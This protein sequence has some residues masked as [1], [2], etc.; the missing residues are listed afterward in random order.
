VLRDARARGDQLSRE[1]ACTILR[2]MRM[3]LGWSVAIAGG[4]GLA[5]AFAAL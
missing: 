4:V 2:R 3:L 5:I 1:Q